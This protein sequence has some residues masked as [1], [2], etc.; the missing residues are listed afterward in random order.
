MKAGTLYIVATPIGNLQDITERAKHVLGSVSIVYGED[1]RVAK[2]LLN[3][4]DLK[5]PAKSYHQHS[6]L[7]TMQEVLDHL[8][9]GEDIAFISDA[10]T[11]A[12]SDP[13]GQLVE[14][15]A[16][17]N[18]EIAIVP[19]GGISAVTSALSISGFPADKFLFLGFPPHK[20]KRK[21][22]FEEVAASPY[23][24]AFYESPHRIEKCLKQLQE[25]L[26]PE[27]EI[28]VCRE[29]TK[30]FESLYRG[31]AGE[32][33]NMNIPAKGEFVVVVRAS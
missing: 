20:N 9:A 21:K 10:G 1:T 19:I 14:Y 28:C 2:R 4:F 15:I 24:V 31:V 33:T 12:I 32:I 6:G 25:V 3:H 22:Y 18:A 8:E 23:T 7:G 5:T 11:P 17:A 27:R 29:L 13:G 16:K 26:H 30:K